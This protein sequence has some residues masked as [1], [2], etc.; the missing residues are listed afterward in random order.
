[1]YTLYEDLTE[2]QQVEELKEFEGCDHQAVIDGDIC[3]LCGMV[4]YN[5]LCSHD[6]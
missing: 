3:V 1:M 6:E 4:L 2:Q 5:C